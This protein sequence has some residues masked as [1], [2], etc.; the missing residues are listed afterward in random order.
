MASDLKRV[1]WLAIC[2]SSV[3]P[4]NIRKRFLLSSTSAIWLIISFRYFDLVFSYY[5]SCSSLIWQLMV[6]VVS[7]GS[8]LATS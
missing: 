1:G 6:W 4:F 3:S 8:S 5:F 7:G 2:L